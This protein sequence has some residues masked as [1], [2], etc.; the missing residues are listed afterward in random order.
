M[1]ASWLHL[2]GTSSCG[3]VLSEVE[4][5]RHDWGIETS[6]PKIHLDQLRQRKKSHPNTD[7]RLLR[8]RKTQCDS[9]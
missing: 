1:F 3:R 8:W 6:P 9:H 5:L 2:Q 4:E 7:W